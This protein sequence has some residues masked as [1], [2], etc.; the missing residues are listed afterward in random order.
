MAR[1]YKDAGVDIDAGDAL[2]ERIKPLAARTRIPGVIADV[3]G[4]AGLF[5]VPAGMREPVL[6]SGTDGVGTKLEIAF[7]A[8]RHETIGQDL[9]AMSANDVAT[10][11]AR[12]LFFLDYYATGRLDVDRAE[13]VMRG[14]AEGCRLAGCALLGGETAELPGFYARG[15]YDLAGFVVG[16]VERSE[17][18][19]GRSV[20]PGDAL[21]GIASTGLHANGYSLA[22]RVLLQD[23]GLALDSRP[24]SLE[25][26][27]V[28][29]LL[30]PTR[31]Y[32]RAIEVARAHGLAA[33]AHITGG[34]LPGNIPRVLPEGLGARIDPRRW[35]R[36]AIFDLVQRL[37]PVEEDEMRC[38]FNLGLGLVMVVPARRADG[39][40]DAL[41]AAGWT[42]ARVGEVV[43]VV[44]E[45]V[46]FEA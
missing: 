44:G 31:I 11:G 25:K 3:G 2:V 29:V 19:D 40:V 21:I 10:T 34:G 5:A 32:V 15:E 36:H 17:I 41:G 20:V 18:L 22:R 28:D 35:K 43:E 12:P 1:T 9:V 13:R 7:A 38:T 42:A 4:F 37:G 8:D 24:E 45:R 46:T 16:I 14:I 30:E 27:L 26:P 23:A 33:A 39:C 6:V